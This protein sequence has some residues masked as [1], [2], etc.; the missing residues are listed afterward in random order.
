MRSSDLTA[1]QIDRLLAGVRR[2]AAYYV[3]AWERA[4]ANGT[5]LDDPLVQGVCRAW[6][7]VVYLERVLEALRDK[8][9]EPYRPLKEPY[10]TSGLA[11]KKQAWAAKQQ[12]ARDAVERERQKVNPPKP[13]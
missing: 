1:E 4:Q 12:A 5:S 10:R 8:L 9:P 6:N 11:A 2:H 3:K 7:E 13:P